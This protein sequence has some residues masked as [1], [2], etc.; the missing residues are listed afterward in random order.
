MRERVRAKLAE[1]G[2]STPEF[3][4]PLF[5]L[6][7]IE[8]QDKAF[9]AVEAE[10]W[11]RRTVL[12]LQTLILRE[13]SHRP[14][15]IILENLH[16]IDKASE[17]L[18]S[19]LIDNIPAFP[20][21]LLISYRPE[22]RLAGADQAHH[23]RFT[24]ECLSEPECLELVQ[25]LLGRRSV[26]EEVKALIL[27]RAE[28]NPL[29]TEE[30]TK[31][32]LEVGALECSE[33]GYSIKKDFSTA[34]IPETIQSL[35][36]ARID[37][38]PESEKRIVQ[39]ASVI[40]R[41]FSLLLIERIMG[42]C[43]QLAESLRHLQ[44]LGLIYAN[45]FAPALRYHFKHAL[46][47]ETSYHSLLTPRRQSLHETTGCAIEENFAGRIEDQLELLSH[48]FT[49]SGNHEKALE[50]LMPAGEKAARLFA[51][52]HA[53]G[54]FQEALKQIEEL[55]GIPVQGRDGKQVET[56]L[57]LEV[58]LD[59][60][61]KREEQGRTLERLIQVASR[62]QDPEIL[63]NAFIRQGE[64]LSV[65]GAT[66]DALAC[67]ERALALKR[68]IGNRRGEAKALRGV[69]FIHWQRTEYRG[70]FEAPSNVTRD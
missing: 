20:V 5:S 17:N 66:N 1:T 63:S 55:S 11:R 21:L 40:G 51:H 64:F 35:I 13:S 14:L 41:E 43:P 45:G 36:M 9:P 23:T 59:S 33:H 7:A 49:R 61:A 2:L 54:F 44:R 62:L 22:Y 31:T 67:V 28:G 60:L 6:L 38:L 8:A 56:L 26:D 52:E 30:L 46:I 32:L 16:W 27:K 50:Y 4:Q 68:Q 48:H 12:V 3:T 37:R 69:A 57:K 58:E 25:D 24:L 65:V 18:L 47:Q 70:E 34:K 19:Q 10:E 39:A 53:I 15:L 42:E 29:Y